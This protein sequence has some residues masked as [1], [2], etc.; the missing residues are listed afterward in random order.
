MLQPNN[1]SSVDYF[2]N[3]LKYTVNTQAVVGSNLI[4]LDV[5]TRFPGGIHDATE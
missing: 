4:F 3:K 1:E 2:S 5:A